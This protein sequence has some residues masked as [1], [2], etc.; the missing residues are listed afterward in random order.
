[1]SLG[2]NELYKQQLPGALNTIMLFTDGDPTAGTFDF[3]SVIKSTSGCKDSTGTAVS[4]GGNMVTKPR[5]WIVYNAEGNVNA[6]PNTVSLGTNSYWSPFSGPIGG[7][8][9]DGSNLYGVSHF[10]VPAGASTGGFEAASG[11]SKTNT[12]APGCTFSASNNYNSPTSDIASVPSTDLFGMS[13]TGYTSSN[14]TV[15]TSNVH[16]SVINLADNAANW[17]R[18]SHTYTNGI[19]MP[20]VTVNVIGLG[21]VNATLLQR[22]ANVAFTGYTP[23]A[24]QPQG[25]YIYAPDQSAL[26]TAFK[27]MA[28]STMRLAQ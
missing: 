16:N 18:S 26:T 15:S 22:M 20:G 5:N 9:G 10:F 24:G 8:Y 17:A 19:T 6:T 11:F 13:T 27:N 14:T 2:W 28:S 23:V 1:M 4:A 25:K 21:S 12:E 3:T 7:L